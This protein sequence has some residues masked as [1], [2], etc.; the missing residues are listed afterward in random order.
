MTA[1]LLRLA[2]ICEFLLAIVA[3]FTAWSE[4]GGQAALDLMHWG[5]KLGLALALAASIVA[6]TAALVTDD[7]WFTLRTA[8]WLAAIVAI[9]VGMGAITYYYSLEEDNTDSDDSSTISRL[10]PPNLLQYSKVLPIRAS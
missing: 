5:W 6:L 9:L 8:R 1:K 7:A 2:Y 10:Q 3:I 4:V